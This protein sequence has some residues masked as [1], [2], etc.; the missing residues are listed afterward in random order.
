MSPKMDEELTSEEISL[1]SLFK[2]HKYLM[3]HKVFPIVAKL[4]RTGFLSYST[5]DPN[6][7]FRVMPTDKGQAFVALLD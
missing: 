1:L 6:C 3:G 7:L 4:L 5:D 2:T